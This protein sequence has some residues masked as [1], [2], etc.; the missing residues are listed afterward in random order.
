MAQLERQAGSGAGTSG[1]SGAHPRRWR[2]IAVV[3]GLTGLA[4]GACSNGLGSSS[5]N[6]SDNGSANDSDNRLTTGAVSIEPLWENGIRAMERPRA[7]DESVVFH[8]LTESGNFQML[9]LDPTSGRTRWTAPASPSNVA[10][11]VGF[12]TR[13][14]HNGEVVVWMEPGESMSAGDITMGYVSIVGAETK[15]GKRLW[16]Y[17]DGRLQL[18]SAPTICGDND[19]CLPASTDSAPVALD[20]W[21]GAPSSLGIRTARASDVGGDRRRLPYRSVTATISKPNH[22]PKDETETTPSTEYS[23]SIGRY[24]Y[25]N[26]HELIAYTS[27]G[28]ESWRKSFSN[29]FE[30]LEVSPSFGWNVT[31]RNGLYIVSLSHVPSPGQLAT[32]EARSPWNRDA[33]KLWAT[34]AIDART[35]ETLWVHPTASTLCG[36]IGS[37]IDEYVRCSYTGTVLYH[38][39]ASAATEGVQVTVEGYDP[40]TGQTTWQWPAGVV[41]GLVFN[42]EDDEAEESDQPRRGPDVLRVDDARYAIRTP[43]RTVL[44]DLEVG[45]LNDPPPASGWCS[46]K[47]SVEPSFRIAGQEDLRYY[48]DLWYPCADG[49]P[50]DVPSTTPRF[51]GV[52]IDE[53]YIWRDSGGRVRGGHVS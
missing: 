40:E 18:S 33:S 24:L 12:S 6:I 23:R 46:S 5:E 17:G 42:S 8:A 52:L 15:S 29:L 20:G 44:L 50:V 36:S 47:T 34:A 31:L 32:D 14:L 26:G 9:S 45:P 21:S 4:A 3:A 38:S 41:P 16:T 2:I 22:V 25:E 7:A 43:D 10:P 30:G 49:H 27:D 48:D 51:A 53:A 13:L 1:S 11:G 39:G 19:V 35:G 28:A 37:G